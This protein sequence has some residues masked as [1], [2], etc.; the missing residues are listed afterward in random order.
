MRPDDLLALL[1]VPGTDVPV[2]LKVESYA[3]GVPYSGWLT[4]PEGV[5]VARLDGF[6]FDFVHFD[7]RLEAARLARLH[8]SRAAR[9]LAPE[10]TLELINL[11]SE[12]IRTKGHWYW[13]ADWL[14][15]NNGEPGTSLSFD[16]SAP[17]IQLCF[18]AHPWSGIA[19]VFVDGVLHGRPDL[20]NESTGVQ[21]S[22]VIENPGGLRR[23]IEVSPTGNANSAALGRQLIFEAVLEATGVERVPS[24]G[25]PAP[26][27][28]GGPFPNQILH[29]LGVMPAD[30]VLLDIGGGRRQID[31]P[32]YLNLEYSAYSEPDLI[33]DALALP[34]RDASVDFIFSSAVMEHLRDPHT[35]GQEIWRV[36][37]PGGAILVNSAFMQPIHSEGMHFFNATPYAMHLVFDRFVERNV[38]WEGS[39]RDT[40]AW[41]LRCT[42][43]TARADAEELAAFDASLTHFDSLIPYDRL[44]YIASGVWISARKP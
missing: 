15:G 1:A 11:R 29:A 14:F 5:V 34:L 16:S 7:P 26:V 22:Y 2:S 28:R 3:E 37:K 12:R 39:L 30:G 41:M 42:G 9:A 4:G 24:Y 43:V 8:Q 13:I 31:D 38:W 44:M 23:H 33:G 6:R 35:F 40:V 20:F 17:R 25:K 36:L 21:S 18:H 32:R 27:N 19:A 10:P